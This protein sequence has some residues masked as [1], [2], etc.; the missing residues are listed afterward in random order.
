[1][2]YQVMQV[3]DMRD[4][5]RDLRFAMNISRTIGDTLRTLKDAL[6]LLQLSY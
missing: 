5:L 4:D 2:N 3:L 6:P 1:M